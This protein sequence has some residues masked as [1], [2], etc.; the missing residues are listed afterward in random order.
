MPKLTWGK[1]RIF[2]EK[3]KYTEIYFIFM[4]RKIKYS[5]MSNL[6]TLSQRF[7]ENSSAGLCRNWQDNSNIYMEEQRTTARQ[8]APE[9]SSVSRKSTFTIRAGCWCKDRKGRLVEW[10]T[11][12]RERITCRTVPQLRRKEKAHSM[13]DSGQL[14]IHMEEKLHTTLPC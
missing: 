6:P 14:L 7:R 4:V 12:P 3:H 11:K 13:C 8:D 5:K 1:L 2:I 10:N 9:A